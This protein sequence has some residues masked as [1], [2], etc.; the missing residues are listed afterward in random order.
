MVATATNNGFATQTTTNRVRRLLD[1]EAALLTVQLVRPPRR[2]R[3]I[4]RVL[5]VLF[6]ALPLALSIV[7][8]QQ[9][10][11]G[12]G[13][14]V[15]YDPVDR[16]QEID[17]P[18]NGRI[19]HWHVVEGSIVKEGDM[20]VE[21]LDNDPELLVRLKDQ[22]D[23]EK[24]KLSSY[25][26]RVNFLKFQ[27][28][29]LNETRERAIEAA[30]GHLEMAKAKVRQARAD[31]YAAEA[32]RDRNVFQLKMQSD[33][34]RKGLVATQ[35]RVLTE[36]DYNMTL[37]Q[38]EAA[39]AAIT[40]AEREVDARQADLDR[41][42]PEQNANIN[43]ALGNLESAVGDVRAIEQAI[44]NLEIRI[45]QQETQNVTAPRDGIIFRILANQTLNGQVVAGQPLVLLVPDVE[46]R[47]AEIYV[48]GNDAPLVH[49][50]DPVRLQFE[51]WPAVQFVGWPSVAVGTFGGRVLIVDPTSNEYGKFRILVE[52]DESP[53]EEPWPSARWLRQGVRA[54]GFVLLQRVPLGY[55]IWRRLN[56][57][58]PVISNQEPSV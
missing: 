10:I 6:V 37:A 25:E 55:E 21:I 15:A 8:W 54:K 43:A 27:V 46:S 51:G 35:D 58:P 40:S 41:V 22:L 26:E 38:I 16:P 39:Q 44:K 13:S 34:E 28:E 47:V 11:T 23:L 30:K 42:E 20:I 52:P 24:A 7:P 12:S 31:L 9:S 29:L 53:G 48:D 45:A 50:G 14:V 57:F 4:G 49:K 5:M 18:V 36:R 56:G 2:C 3:Q 17:S 1:T 32:A 33:L 19:R